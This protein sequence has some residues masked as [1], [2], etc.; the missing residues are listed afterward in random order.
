[1]SI[2]ASRAFGVAIVGACS[3]ARR[4]RT[5]S[6]W[7]RSL[8]RTGRSDASNRS[9]KSGKRGNSTA[10][11]SLIW[12]LA[13]AGSSGLETGMETVAVAVSPPASAIVYEKGYLPAQVA[14]GLLRIVPPG[15][16]AT[17]T[18]PVLHDT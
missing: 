7:L 15:L 4:F 6:V 11:P 17:A 8:P 2:K 14:R 5:P 18:P 13:S 3:C 9:L 10:K 12:R 16:R 1:L